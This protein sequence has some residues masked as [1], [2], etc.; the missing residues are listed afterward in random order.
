MS[1]KTMCNSA[2]WYLV[3]TKIS[4]LSGLTF[5]ESWIVGAPNFL[6]GFTILKTLFVVWFDCFS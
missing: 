3:K 1:E 2:S 5:V 6:S 4:G